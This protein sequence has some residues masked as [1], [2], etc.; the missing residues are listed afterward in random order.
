VASL[1]RRRDA[2][3]VHVVPELVGNPARH[4]RAVVS[5]CRVDRVPGA[6]RWR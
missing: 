2:W 5:G 3:G 1:I 4:V 6:P